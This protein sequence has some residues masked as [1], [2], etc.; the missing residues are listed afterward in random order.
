MINIKHWRFEIVSYVHVHI[1]KYFEN[2]PLSILMNLSYLSVMFGFLL[3][4]TL[5]Y[6]ILYCFSHIQLFHKKSD[7][8]TSFLGVK[9]NIVSHFMCLEL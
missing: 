1:K 5:I 2:F 7:N 8:E 4:I 9:K 6:I 3:K